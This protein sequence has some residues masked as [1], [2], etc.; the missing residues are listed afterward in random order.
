VPAAR[1][2]DPR[3]LVLGAGLVMVLAQV[4]F[5]SWV[6][7]PSW[8][9]LDDYN[10]L[11]DAVGRPVTVGYLLDPYNSHLMPGGRLLVWLVARTG[12]LSWGLAAGLTL[13]LQALAG[14]AA[15]WMVLSLFGRRWAALAPLALYLSTAMTVPALVWWAAALNQVPLQAAFFAAVAT[16]V[17]Y[18]RTR[19]V[20]WLLATVAVVVLGLFFYVKAVLL[21]PVLG[22]LTLAYFASGS[23]RARVRTVARRDRLAAALGLLVLVGYLVLY[24]VGADQPFTRTRLTVVGEIADSMV[25]T[26]FTTGLLGGPWRWATL[27]PP[28]AFAS[29]PGWSVHLAWVVVV[30]VVLYGA[31]RRRGTLRAW[32]LLAGYLVALL[33]LLVDSRAPV[34]GQVIGLEYRYL[35]DAAC[36]A[37]LSVG[38]AFLP[39]LGA[40]QASSPRDE[41]LL[42]LRVPDRVVVGLLVLVCASGLYSS[43][44]YA[45][46][47]HSD[48]ASDGYVH[49]LGDDLAAAGTVDL[50]D[51]RLPE[52]VMSG[53]AFPDNTVRRMTRLLSD[54]VAYPDATSRL[55]AVAPDGSLR[56]ALI[57]PGLASRPGPLEDCGWRVGRRGRAVPLTGRAF[58]YDWW[59]RIG[60]LSSAGSPVEVRAGTSRVAGQLA[61]GVHSLYVHVRGSFAR[62]TLTGLDPGVTLC[63]D[64]IEV[65]TPVP[66]GLLP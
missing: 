15:L 45:G 1:G 20:R 38:L 37:T 43:A 52:A 23:L 28:T 22:F 27:A 34:Y 62:V 47:W 35:T 53:L 54:R 31:L 63:V 33:A 48:N 40:T 4:A 3:S 9:F 32:A 13:L 36:A 25:G 46:Y 58:D 6:V 50:V 44:A 66:G 29:P 17:A 14:L 10:L 2:R 30:L 18:Q 5:R 49:R 11:N 16:W 51:A 39:L 19:R 12:P 55:A 24:L 26:A 64:T 7:S 60:Y 8:F 41:P 21:L 65:G 57:Q 59:L 56:T 42:T 61:A